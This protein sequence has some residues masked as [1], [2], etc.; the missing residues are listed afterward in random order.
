MHKTEFI[1]FINRTGKNI[2]ETQN[3]K[4]ANF[5]GISEGAIRLMKEK[6]LHRIVRLIKKDCNYLGVNNRR[7]RNFREERKKAKKWK[8]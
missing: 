2:S 5:I 6:D 7:K 4:L 3:T 1:D 8:Y